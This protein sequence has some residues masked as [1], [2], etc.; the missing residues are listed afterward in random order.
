MLCVVFLGGESIGMSPFQT[1]DSCSNLGTVRKFLL[2]DW[3]PAGMFRCASRKIRLWSAISLVRSSA[4]KR[5]FGISVVLSLVTLFQ[6]GCMSRRITVRTQ[7]AGA[8]V[9]M[10]GKRLGPSPVSTNFTYYGDNEFKI[11]APGYETAV[12]RQPTPAPW[13]QVP[14][15]DFISDNFLP[16]RVRDH[17]EYN[18]S[19]TPRD[20]LQ[21][22]DEQGLR[23]RGEN[24]R[25]QSQSGP[26]LP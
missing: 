20:P 21:E 23:S 11:S 8:L 14:P 12:V 16:F 25:S 5:V 10:N 1:S 2:V 15:L 13:Y 4:V 22:M 9:E 19:L 26:V 18:Y 17:R 7:P 24:F 3:Q 6:S